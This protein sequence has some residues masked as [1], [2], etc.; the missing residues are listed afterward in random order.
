MQ[1]YKSIWT[2]HVTLLCLMEVFPVSQTKPSVWPL[3]AGRSASNVSVAVCGFVEHTQ[4]F[5]L[6]LEHKSERAQRPT[7]SETRP[8]YHLKEN[9]R[10]NT[11][12]LYSHTHFPQ[13]EEVP[14]TLNISTRPLFGKTALHAAY[15]DS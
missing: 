14:P 9:R 6:I 10:V 13:P 12:G 15:L 5:S 2:Q 4:R 7:A 8:T 1:S 3:F 11:A